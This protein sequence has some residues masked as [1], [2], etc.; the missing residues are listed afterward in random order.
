MKQSFVIVAL[1]TVLVA[2]SSTSAR[3][4]DGASLTDRPAPNFSGTYVDSVRPA[5]CAPGDAHQAY[6]RR[7]ITQMP[8]EPDHQPRPA[9]A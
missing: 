9:S 2:S 4:T 1:L 5:S 6:C 7:S 3:Q 8:C